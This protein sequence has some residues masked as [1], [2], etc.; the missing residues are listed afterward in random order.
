MRYLMYPELRKFGKG[1]KNTTGQEINDE[2]QSDQ[3]IA[4]G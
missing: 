3:D 2:I 1:P 4:S